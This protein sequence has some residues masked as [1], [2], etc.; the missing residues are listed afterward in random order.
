MP[1]LLADGNNFY[2]SCERIFDP[3]LLGR[4]VVVLSN[5]D[6]RVVARSPE[7]KALGIKMGVP[8]FQI[9]QLV[10]REGVKAY[11]SNYELNGDMSARVIAALREFTDTVEVYSIDE[12]FVDLSGC[13]RAGTSAER[14]K[15]KF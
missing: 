1:F 5:N 9:K 8:L 4:P 6:G 10:E 12:A 7:A 2:V 14:S 15:R 3:T 11:S 13:W